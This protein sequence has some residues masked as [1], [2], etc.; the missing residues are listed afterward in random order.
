M[1]KETT[2]LRLIYPQW[3]GGIVDHWMPVFRHPVCTFALP[4]GGEG[5]FFFFISLLFTVFFFSRMVPSSF[6]P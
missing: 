4:S 6:H 3:Q 1:K 5:W 2:P